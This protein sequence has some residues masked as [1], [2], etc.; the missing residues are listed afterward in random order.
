MKTAVLYYSL[1][2]NTKKT[3][4]TI[5]EAVGGDAVRIEP[6]RDIPKRGFFR[7]VIGGFMAG[8]K[9]R[10]KLEPIMH[11]LS[12][13]D[14]FFVGSPVWASTVTPAVRTFLSENQLE[15]KDV[16]LFACFAGN[17]GKCLAEMKSLIPNANII[18]E[19]KLIDPLK[20]KNT[21]YLEKIA[22]WAKGVCEAE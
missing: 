22:R 5:A 13:Y 14:R 7:Y 20:E 18:G 1:E 19:Q 6:I 16:A 12:K 17:D 4:E 9:R 10:V 21:R 2:G 8:T 3:A 11:D 15:K